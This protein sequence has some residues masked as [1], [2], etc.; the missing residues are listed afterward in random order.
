MRSITIYRHP[1]AMEGDRAEGGEMGTKSM[2][3]RTVILLASLECS[4]VK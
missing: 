3:M 4:G 1:G 2:K